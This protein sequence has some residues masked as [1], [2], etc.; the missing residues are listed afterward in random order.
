[1]ALLQKT[2]DDAHAWD[3][4]TK[5]EKVLSKFLLDGHAQFNDLSGGLKCRA[6]L[7]KAL[8]QSPDLLL[9]DEP[10]NHLDIPSI[11]CLESFLPQFTGSILFITHD[12]SFLQHIATDIIELDRGKIFSFPGNYEHFLTQ[13]ETYL[14]VEATKNKVFDKQLKQEE[15]SISQG[16]KARRKRN[17]GR[18]RTLKAMRKAKM[19]RKAQQGNV[20][21]NLAK[22]TQSSKVVICTDHINF[23]YEDN[24]I[25]SNF[26]CDIHRGDKIALLGPNGSGKS[27][28]LQILLKKLV[29]NTGNVTHGPNLQIAYFDQMRNQINTCLSLVENI[30]EGG[31]YLDID[32]KKIHVVG[33]LQQ[34]L[35]DPRCL[36]SPASLLSGGEKNRLLLAKLFAKPS[37][38]LV[39]DEPTN[40]LDIET[41]EVLEQLIIQYHGTVLI[42]SHDRSFINNTVTST[43]VLEGDGKV[44]E[45][46]GGYDDWLR[47]KKSHEH[48]KKVDIAKST[49]SYQSKPKAK[50]NNVSYAERQQLEALPQEIE[51]L[52]KEIAALQNKT[53]NA[54]FYQQDKTDIKKTLKIL[55]LQTK[56]LEEKYQK[57][58]ILSSNFKR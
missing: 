18:K 4:Q 40:D 7:A 54:S 55:S 44:E 20:S 14:E 2:I 5:V 36:Q 24:V 37:N 10:T 47:Q 1:M 38:V 17:E 50:K 8:V 13:K 19:E 15:D 16:I 23:S 12:R 9:L 42:A 25:V 11:E 31:N 53:A 30:T 45:Y 32:G 27:T 35:F 58:T 6:L 39:L 57:W 34:F 3:L 52:E 21:V 41:L 29:P 51:K 48:K 26:S 28:L 43:I 49:Q 56:L 22:A 46:V 33:Y